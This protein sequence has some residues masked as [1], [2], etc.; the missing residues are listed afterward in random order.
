MA[1]EEPFALAGRAATAL[2]ERT[3]VPRHDVF[4]VLGSGWIH[5]AGLLPD[6]VDVPM[7]ELP[8][9]GVPSVE[10]HGSQ[11]RS[12]MIGDRR[13]LLALGRVH[14]YEGH[15]PASVVHGVRMA[16]ASGCRVAVLTNASGSLH[17]EWPV[18]GAVVIADQINFTGL[19]PLTGPNPPADRPGRFA[20]MT[21]VYAPRL[22]SL[23][24]EIEPGLPEGV[25]MGFH[26][27][28]F[29][30]P[31][32]VRAARAWGADLVGM[33][34]VLEVIAAAHLGLEVLGLSL[35]TNLAAGVREEGPL[36]IGHVLAVAEASAPVIADLLRRVLLR[37][38]DG[39]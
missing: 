21:D 5:V 20:N 36:D 7:A 37:L 13:I 25:Y 29:E 34:T 39:Q 4:V 32:E 30:T 18:G 24:Q 3:G 38:S 17:R 31:A 8:G 2:A 16:A 12:L 19:S 22:R 14:L 33:S 1:D 28:E 15:S 26:G 11:L 35:A 10:G 6:G 23:V 27:P 9:F